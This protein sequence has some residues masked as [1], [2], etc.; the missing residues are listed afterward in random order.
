MAADSRRAHWLPSHIQVSL[1][2]VA[3]SPPTRSTCDLVESYTKLTARGQSGALIRLEGDGHGVAVGEAVADGVGVG[4]AEG[5]AMAK[6][7][8]V[9]DV[10]ASG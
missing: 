9:G 8:G 6:G 5:V 1:L 3:P 2:M 7:V 10:T 4:D